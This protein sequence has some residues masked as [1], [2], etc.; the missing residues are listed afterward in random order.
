MR[1]HDA[2]NRIDDLAT[3][4][5]VWTT[6][7]TLVEHIEQCPTC[8]EYAVVSDKLSGLITAGREDDAVGAT[9]IEMQRQQ[10][11]AR[12]ASSKRPTRT[13]TV[14]WSW[15]PDLSMTHRPVLRAGIATMVLLITAVSIIPFTFHR[16]VGY[17]LNFDGVDHQLVHDDELICELLTDLGLLEAGVDRCGCDATAC[18][19]S[20]L[21]LKSEQE[22][23]LVAGAIGRL[24]DE[25]LTTKITPIRAKASLSLL[26]RASDMFKRATS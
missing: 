8:A 9:P 14:A 16:T 23:I 10:V 4:G 22:V 12:A 25:T 15:L 19:L 26:Q 13:R 5:I 17:D 3:S 2:K 1:C 6:D 11:E 24:H 18:C 21:D 7:A 20:I